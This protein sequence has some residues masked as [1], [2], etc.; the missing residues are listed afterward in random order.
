MKRRAG[1]PS[2]WAEAGVVLAAEGEQLGEEGLSLDEGAV[3]LVCLPVSEREGGSA[4]V[5]RE[6]GKE[7][8]RGRG[9]EGGKERGG[10]RGG[11][12]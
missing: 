10:G 4:T 2:G 9:R 6:G 1:R 8:G 12:T 3:V 7:G 11:R 5:G